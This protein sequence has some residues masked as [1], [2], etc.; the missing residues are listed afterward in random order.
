MALSLEPSIKKAD[1]ADF[2]QKMS[3]L[4]DTGYDSCSAAKLLA[5]NGNQKKKGK[6]HS[7]D[8]IR[9]VA[10]LL[11]PDLS[12]GFSLHEAM[13]AHPKYFETFA[14]QVEVGEASGK[15]A[16]VLQRICDQIKN[17]GKIMAKL[18]SALSY[19]LFT[20]VFT[21][22]AAGYLFTNVVPEML[23]M[24]S[25]VGSG[26]MPATTQLVMQ[27]GEWLSAN[28]LLLVVLIGGLTGVFFAYA[29]TIG[30]MR[31]AKI[32]VTMPVIGMV[33]QNNA[34]TLFF[35]NWQQMIMA[36]AEMSVALQS[37]AES[38][39]NLFL[40]KQML[41]ARTQYAENGIPVYEA[42]RGVDSLRELELQTIQV[43]ME[44]GKLGR[45]LGI[46]AEDREIEAQKSI[47]SMTSA[48]NPIM[49]VFVGLIVGL[50]VMS[51]YEPIINVSNT[52]G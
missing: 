13:G 51:I 18:K 33:L 26:D 43:A 42:L 7:A 24:L 29:K 25:S 40:R 39:P 8:S 21:F 3:M 28:G 47:N 20:L 5:F 32:T 9:R 50:L 49:M 34:M 12:E 1:L 19:P 14:N 46:L 44:G 31:V 27:I 4:I 2:F 15:T 36:G 10:N 38:I 6:D 16:E 41:A 48:I 11:L 30:K 35:K 23:D 45:T 37:A 22:A 52:I 17:E